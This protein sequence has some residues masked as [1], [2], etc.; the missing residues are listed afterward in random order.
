MG[1]R[2]NVETET[3]SNT[4]RVAEPAGDPRLC[5]DPTSRSA[6]GGPRAVLGCRVFRDPRA[7]KRGEEGCVPSGE[8]LHDPGSGGFCR[9]GL[10]GHQGTTQA[11]FWQCF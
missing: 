8:N 4:G 1:A 10:A 2:A 7:G 11:M 3:H 6:G 9:A 5:R